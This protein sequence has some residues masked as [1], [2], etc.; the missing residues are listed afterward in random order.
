MFFGV[1]PI[2]TKISCVPYMLDYG[3]RG[4]LIAGDLSQGVIQITH[5]LKDVDELELMAEKASN[6]SQNYTLDVFEAEISKLLQP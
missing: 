5:S 2:A 1:I 6:W 4:I 3:N